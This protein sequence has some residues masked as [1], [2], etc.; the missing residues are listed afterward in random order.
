MLFKFDAGCVMPR[1]KGAQI[2]REC[3]FPEREGGGAERGSH[4]A[5]QVSKSRAAAALDVLIYYARIMF[6]RG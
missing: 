3:S 4:Y 6:G 5:A 1:S 2:P